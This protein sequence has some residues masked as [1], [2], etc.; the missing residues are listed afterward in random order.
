MSQWQHSVAQNER[1]RS[2]FHVKHWVLGKW[3]ARFPSVSARTSPI[4]TSVQ[5]LLF[6]LWLL[7]E[8]ISGTSALRIWDAVYNVYIQSSNSPD[9]LIELSRSRASRTRSTRTEL[10]QLQINCQFNPNGPSN[11]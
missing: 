10:A 5:C 8:S 11:G 3:S 9:A 4:A 1:K 6:L 7:K 2:I